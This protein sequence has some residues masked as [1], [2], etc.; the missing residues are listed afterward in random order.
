MR[1]FGDD[2]GA[3]FAVRDQGQGFPNEDATHLFDKYFRSVAERQRKVPGSGL[4]LFIVKTVAE[5]HNGEVFARS[6]PGEGAEFEMIIPI[7]Q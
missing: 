4:G 2:K 3:H 1:A 5:R 7:H 6:A